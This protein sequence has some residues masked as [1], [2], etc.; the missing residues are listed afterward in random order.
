MR[1]FQGPRDDR[2]LS[3][4]RYWHGATESAILQSAAQW[5]NAGVLDARVLAFLDAMGAAARAAGRQVTIGRML[6]A[7]ARKA[8]LVC[9]VKDLNWANAETLSLIAHLAIRT[10][11]APILLMLT[12]RLEGDPVT[13]AWRETATPAE[14]ETI[15]L[16]PLNPREAR[17]L[18]DLNHSQKRHLIEECL[19][20]A[21]GNPLSLDQLLRHASDMAREVVPG[22]S[23]A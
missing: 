18:I 22:P 19:Q 13:P 20:K 8:P 2:D 14:I 12:T 5:Q 6:I 21:E 3:R 23:K 17:A 11:E 7:S 9:T 1:K 15:T 16:S 4:S 10:T